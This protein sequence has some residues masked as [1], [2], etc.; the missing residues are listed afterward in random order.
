MA[1]ALGQLF[2]VFA[3][4]SKSPE[5]DTCARSECNTAALNMLKIDSYTSEEAMKLKI[6]NDVKCEFFSII[7]KHIIK[8]DSNKEDL[9]D[10]FCSILISIIVPLLS[11]WIDGCAASNRGLQAVLC[12]AFRA[13][14]PSVNGNIPSSGK[15]NVALSFARCWSAYHTQYQ[16]LGDEA[17]GFILVAFLSEVCNEA[18]LIHRDGDSKNRERRTCL[19]DALLDFT[20]SIKR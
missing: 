14:E 17:R 1:A 16:I 9:R 2:I 8:V 4:F 11:C 18:L 6:D 3:I 7:L 12:E 20:A 19:I 15:T 13:L 10:F 5:L